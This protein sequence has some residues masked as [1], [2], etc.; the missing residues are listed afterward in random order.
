MVRQELRS[1][2]DL[3]RALHDALL[4]ASE[5]VTNAVRHS[6][7]RED[8]FLTVGVTRDERLRVAVL[9]PGA[10]GQSA[11]IANRPVELGGLGLKVVEELAAAWGT[12]RRDNGYRVWAELEL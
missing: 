11:E 4:V 1:L 7:C 3:G 2:R 5:L 9:D 6:L 10:S 8:E 12:E